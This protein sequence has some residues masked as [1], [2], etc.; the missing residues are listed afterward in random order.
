M[1][2]QR[3]ADVLAYIHEVNK[4]GTSPTYD[5][6]CAHVGLVSKSGVHR[7]VVALEERGFIRRSKSRVRALEVIRTASSIGQIKDDF[8]R[9]FEAGYAKGLEEGKG[10]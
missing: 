6:I 3:Q 1:L 2:T 5:E 9:G 4:R 7:L 8:Q 10:K